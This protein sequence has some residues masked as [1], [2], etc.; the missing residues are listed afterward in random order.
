VLKRYTLIFLNDACLN[1]FVHIE[2][3]LLGTLLWL[4]FFQ[5]KSLLLRIYIICAL[6]VLNITDIEGKWN[7]W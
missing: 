7:H 5:F 1:I 6:S 2:L 4:F 3:G